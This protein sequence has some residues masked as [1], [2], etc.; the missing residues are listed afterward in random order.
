MQESTIIPRRDEAALAR[1]W[2]KLR[3][4]EIVERPDE[5]KSA[6]MY[7]EW[8]VRK[9]SG[10]KARRAQK[11]AESRR[12][13]MRHMPKGKDVYAATLAEK[14]GRSPQSVGA[15]LR[16]MA[17]DGLVTVRYAKTTTATGTTE[18]GLWRRV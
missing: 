4:Q 11:R 17:H 16:S 15:I 5:V 12:E 14:T 3:L 10:A 9:S 18:L 2:R 1:A 8:R 13:I 6:I 7:D